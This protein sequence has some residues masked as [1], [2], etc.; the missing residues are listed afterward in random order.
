LNAGTKAC[1]ANQCTCANG[2]AAI[3]AA[4][5][6]HN[7]V[8]CESCSA[9]YH[10]RYNHW[11]LK[12]FVLPQLL[13]NISKFRFVSFEY[14]CVQREQVLLREWCQRNRCRMREARRC[15]LQVLQCRIQWH[16][17]PR[18]S[19]DGLTIRN[20]FELSAMRCRLW[21]YGVRIAHRRV[22]TRPHICVQF[23]YH[24]ST[25]RASARRVAHWNQIIVNIEVPG[26]ALLCPATPPAC[27]FSRAPPPSLPTSWSKRQHTSVCT[28]PPPPSPLYRQTRICRDLHWRHFNIILYII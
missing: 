10:L 20:V 13:S 24:K 15:E 9:G 16:G 17:V 3:G 12:S 25:H 23:V 26:R 11:T 28:T 19:Y 14:E 22:A 1:D 6:Q 5:D 27:P 8:K 2:V 21:K 7:D 18:Q 4:C